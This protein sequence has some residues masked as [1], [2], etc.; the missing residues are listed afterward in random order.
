[1][2]GGCR[3]SD[4]DMRHSTNLERIPIPQERDAL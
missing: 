1:M 2:R 4:K 3:F